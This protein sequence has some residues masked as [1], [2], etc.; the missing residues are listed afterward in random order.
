MASLPGDKSALLAH[1]LKCPSPSSLQSVQLQILGV[2]CEQ[3]LNVAE[4]YVHVC[5]ISSSARYS[6]CFS[7]IVLHSSLPCSC[8]ALTMYQ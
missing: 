3:S 8:P 1:P 4:Y 7:R 5:Q 6:A 2:N